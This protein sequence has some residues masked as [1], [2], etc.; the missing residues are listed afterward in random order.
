[1]CNLI[2]ISVVLIS[3]VAIVELAKVNPKLDFSEVSDLVGNNRDLVKS[4]RI[5][6]LKVTVDTSDSRG[7]PGA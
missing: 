5:K 3:W 2:K 6:A 7:S 1:M 4:T